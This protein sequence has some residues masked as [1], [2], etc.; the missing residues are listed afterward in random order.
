MNKRV[1]I[2]FFLFCLTLSFL[3][4][5]I[6]EIGSGR[7]AAGAAQN[8]SLRLPIAERRGTLYDCNGLPLVNAVP[9]L[10]GAAK[11]TARA[12][13]TL[14]GILP[15]QE[16]SALRVRLEKGSPA[17]FVFPQGAQV[18][19]NPDI[20][21]LPVWQRYDAQP[22]AVHLLGYLGADG[23]GVSGLEKS[24][25]SYLAAQTGRLAVRFP[26]DAQGRVLPGGAAEIENTGYDSAA[27]LQLT[28]DRRIQQITQE[29]MAQ[30]H[31]RAG[32]A[33]VLDCRSGAVRAMVSTPGFHPERV[34]ESLTAQDA[35]LINR[36]ILPAAVGSVFKPILA[37][38]ALE[39]GIPIQQEFVC[40]GEVRV[41]DTVFRCHKREGHGVLDMRGAVAE[42]CNPYFI[43]L[44]QRLTPQQILPA[45]RGAGFGQ[46]TPLA[47]ELTSAAGILP[48][49]AELLLPAALANFSFGQGRLLATPL[50]L[51][52]AFACI[53]ADGLYHTPYLTQVFLDKNGQPE[54][55]YSAIPPEQVLR[56]ETAQTLR[57]LLI[58]AVEEG[59]GKR[60]KP[61]QGGAGGKT[62]TAQT[63]VFVNG[64][65]QVNSWFVGFFPAE[66]PQYVIAI[67]V[68]Q[69]SS[70]GI[71][72][73]P[74][75]QAIA[76]R[77]RS[78]ML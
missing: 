20:L 22:L 7:F 9:S 77:I 39:N 4:L 58:S 12:L 26:A 66:K 10:M 21:C 51:A 48:N 76:D 78:D 3:C 57:S 73:A 63:G 33:V 18:P 25:D 17:A 40:T 38:A 50:Q 35:P 75:F 5:R 2:L 19:Q 49:E 59:S 67:L 8:H 30:P 15:P 44:M 56:P 74:V 71:D 69:G 1:I 16:L 61:A 45:V 70:G 47:P 32:A 36:A 27:G 23:H 6:V 68:E 13:D 42:S 53:A 37:A 29:A 31:I 34:G 52:A 60:A 62:A 54:A 55:P 41:G 43:Q 65:E 11:P 72:C 64:D 24:Y 14:T 46:Q 28:L